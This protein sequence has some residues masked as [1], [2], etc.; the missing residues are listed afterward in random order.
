MKITDTALSIKSILNVHKGRIPPSSPVC[1]SR[2]SD[3][4][5]YVLSGFADYTFKKKTYTASAGDII[6]L[7]HKSAYSIN[8]TDDNYTFIFIDFYF[9]S[10][11]KIVFENEIYKSKVVSL[12]KSNFEKFFHLWTKGDFSDKVYCKSLIYKI[13]SQI[14]KSSLCDYVS[15]HRRHQIE[16]IAQYIAE[17]LADSSLSVSKL[18]QMCDISEVHFRRIFSHIYR[19]S[20]LKYINSVR[21]NKAKE[22]LLS[23]SFSIY[24]IS[25]MCGFENHHY[26]SKIFKEETNMTPSKFRNYY[27]SNI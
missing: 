10:D 8:V 24:E 21:L 22:L 11:K 27:K 16:G 5:V 13:Y 17:N 4:F 6:Y 7:A 1:A 12:L 2:H 20:P 26:F 23:D 3:C 25:L 9:E 18:S 15:S 19:T 14:I